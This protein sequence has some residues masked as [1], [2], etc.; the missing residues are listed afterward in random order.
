[1]HHGRCSSTQETGQHLG[2]YKMVFVKQTDNKEKDMLITED[3]NFSN[4]FYILMFEFTQN[5][6]KQFSTEKMC[7]FDS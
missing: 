1:M 5:E 4:S 2:R 3:N 7:V 6:R